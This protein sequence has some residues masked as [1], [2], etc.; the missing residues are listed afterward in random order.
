MSFRRIILHLLIWAGV[1]T[2]WLL[3]TK[4]FHPNMTIAA[5]AT[6]LLVTGSA[7]MVYL[8]SLFLLPRFARQGCWLQ[9][10]IALL[11]TLAILDLITV[12]AIQL[13]YD[14]LW[15]PDPLRFGF[16]FNLSSDGFIIALHL[17]VAT[18]ISWLN[19]LLLRR[20]PQSQPVRD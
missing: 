1:F 13:I 16:W 8:N 20:R 18:G 17:A 2:F 12:Q 11:M 3:S 14:A 9:Y 15:H 19:K 6:G 5:A 7:L 4:Q 10:F